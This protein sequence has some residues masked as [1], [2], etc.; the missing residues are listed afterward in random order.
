[1]TV[2]TSELDKVKRREYKLAH[3]GY[4]ST[5]MLDA[6]VR[7]AYALDLATAVRDARADERHKMSTA[8]SLLTQE[9]K[10][11]ALYDIDKPDPG[12]FVSRDEE[13]RLRAQAIVDVWD[14]FEELGTRT[15]PSS[16]PATST[17]RT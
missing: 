6:E 17:T 9:I 16:W 1:M 11:H 4:A 5:L 2:K 7:I 8:L 12:R 14:A 3:G 13:Y 10:R 15:S